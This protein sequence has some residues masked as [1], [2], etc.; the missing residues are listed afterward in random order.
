MVLIDAPKLTRASST[1]CLP[2][3]FQVMYA[4]E[5]RALLK[6]NEIMIVILFSDELQHNL[7]TLPSFFAD[8]RSISTVH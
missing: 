5:T 7:R 6:S 4:E 1:V 3:C 8:L 2:A